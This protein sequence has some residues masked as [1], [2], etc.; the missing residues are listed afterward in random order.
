MKFFDISG[1]E[2]DK[3][4]FISLYNDSYYIDYVD[5]TDRKGNKR[6]IRKK[7]MCPD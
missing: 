5:Y 1:G 2:I 6:K 7:S 3:N 4:Q